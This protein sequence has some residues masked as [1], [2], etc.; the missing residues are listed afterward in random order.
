M[1]YLNSKLNVSILLARFATSVFIYPTII[2]CIPN[3][4]VLAAS[5]ESGSTLSLIQADALSTKIIP[6]IGL[7]QTFTTLEGEFHSNQQVYF[8]RLFI[9]NFSVLLTL[10]YK[11]VKLL[12][13][14]AF[15]MVYLDFIFVIKYFHVNFD[16]NTMNCMD[17]STPMHSSDFL[18][19]QTC[20][21]DT[22]FLMMS[23]LIP[24][25][26]SLKITKINHFIFLVLLMLKASIL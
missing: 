25:P 15:M 9:L 21:C 13:V 24:L 8:S 2:Q 16:D 17:K 19:D 3:Q 20:C 10:T 6:Y 5:F 4:Q 18:S 14:L 7:H 22:M 23:R 11:L 1:I 26:P 12:L